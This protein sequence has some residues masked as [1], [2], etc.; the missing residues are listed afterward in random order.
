MRYVI[1][2]WKMYPTVGEAVGLFRAIQDGLGA[3]ADRADRV[4]LPIICPP[5][6]A[7]VAV[8]ALMD[9]RL[10]RL[11]A[12]NCH[13]EQAGPYTG[14]ISAAMLAD[15]VDYVL[16]GHSERRAVGETEEHVAK[17]VA[18][19]GQAGLVPIVFVGEDSPTDAGI[20]QS[21][22]RLRHRLSRVDLADTSVL[23][24]YEPVWAIGAER[25]ADAEHVREAAE[26]LKVTLRE[27]GAARPQ[28]L[29]GGTVRRDNV[30]RFAALEVLDGVG[31]T[32]GSL[33]ARE[34]LDILSQ[35]ARS[36]PGAPRAP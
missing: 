11:G 13:W 34:F 36:S 16:V 35:V 19:V 29:Y 20:R 5:F 17:K 10:V 22:E 32:R 31:A 21:E 2:N 23:V 33:D 15:A 8:R 28:V 12:Q 3:A 7:L 27:L 4:P 18:A 25:P 14:E 9:E 24:V 1:A 26:H 30:E 6:L